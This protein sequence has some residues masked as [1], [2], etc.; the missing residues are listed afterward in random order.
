[1]KINREVAY[2]FLDTLAD[3]Y[4]SFR[5]EAPD[6]DKGLTK[7]AREAVDF[8]SACGADL[9]TVLGLEFMEDEENDD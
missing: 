1:M 4:T 9:L 7:L 2:N 6:N 3:A 8:V 5:Y